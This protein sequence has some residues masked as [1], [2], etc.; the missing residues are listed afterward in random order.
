MSKKKGRA[1]LYWAATHRITSS[2]RSRIEASDSSGEISG[3]CDTAFNK[4]GL[5]IQYNISRTRQGN[6]KVG[7]CDL[8]R[9]PQITRSC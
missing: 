2:A 4:T 7:S 3:T 6:V 1:K 8:I 9:I 5:N